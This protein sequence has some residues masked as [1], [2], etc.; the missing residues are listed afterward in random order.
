MS[1]RR[2]LENATHP[3][4]GL[5]SR[6]Q[7]SAIQWGREVDREFDVD[8][9]QVPGGQDLVMLGRLRAIWF[10]DG[11]VFKPLRPYPYLTIGERD[12]RI[13]FVGGSTAKMARSRE[14]GR[15]GSRRATHRID[16]ESRK[17]LPH[18]SRKLATYFYHDHAAG[19]SFLGVRADG[20][21]TYTG[22]YTVRP[23]GIVG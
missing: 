7:Y 14:W 8:A 23:E 19:P 17:G 18:G 16:Y 3:L 13:Y 4:G 12:H 2:W 1:L 22:P 15:P 21:P 6:D 5:D 10:T 11:Y 20:F 9:P